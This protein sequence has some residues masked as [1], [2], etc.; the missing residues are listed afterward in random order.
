M[1]TTSGVVPSPDD[2]FADC[3]HRRVSIAPARRAGRRKGRPTIG[4]GIVAPAI[5]EERRADA[6]VSAP[7]D[8]LAARPH[9]GVLTTRGWG[10]RDG[11]GRPG[12]SRGIIAPA[13]IE[14]AALEPAPDDHF[15]A[16]PHRRV[17]VAPGG[18]AGGGHR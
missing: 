8:H 17:P 1:V 2:H 13:I 4:H 10:T 11:H 6:V 7:D 18:A 12:V 3:P 5:V 16:R 14:I 15:A 9:R